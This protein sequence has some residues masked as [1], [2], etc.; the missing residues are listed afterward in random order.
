MIQWLKNI[1]RTKISAMFHK[2]G[3][4]F[5]VIFLTG[6]IAGGGFSKQMVETRLQDAVL[7]GGVVI[8]NVVY[9]ITPR[10]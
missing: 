6:F 10:P 8:K 7:L 3:F 9:N 4:W 5:I 1:D 2:A